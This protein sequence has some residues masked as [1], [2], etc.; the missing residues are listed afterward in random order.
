MFHTLMALFGYF[1]AVLGF[2]RLLERTIFGAYFKTPFGEIT[3]V[4]FIGAL[5]LYENYLF[6]GGRV[7]VV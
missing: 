4:I 2:N 6:S 7:F 3:Y 5:V 1:L